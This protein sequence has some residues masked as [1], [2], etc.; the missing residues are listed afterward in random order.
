MLIFFFL[1][2]KLDCLTDEQSC[3][4]FRSLKPELVSLMLNAFHSEKDS[5]NIQMILGGFITLLE[6][7]SF[8]ELEQT[9]RRNEGVKSASKKDVL[10]GVT[11]Q[12][13]PDG[14]PGKTF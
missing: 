10:N 4:V 3:T 7:T 14:L 12:T 13:V 11:N 5:L 1:F 9:I 8:Y 2:F 6:D